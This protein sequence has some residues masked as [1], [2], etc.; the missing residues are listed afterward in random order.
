MRRTIAGALR[1]A[2]VGGLTL[3]GACAPLPFPEPHAVP[4]ASIRGPV[5]TF[6]VPTDAAPS[7]VVEL[8]LRGEE[9]P[10]NG[11]G[12]VSVSSVPVCEAA[13]LVVATAL[14]GSVACTVPP[15]SRV[16]VHVSE[17]DP[18][19]VLAAFI[20]AV[21]RL[22]VETVVRGGTLVLSGG[23]P[24][25]AEGYG[26]PPPAGLPGTDPAGA[27]TFTLETDPGSDVTLAAVLGQLANP[28][29]APL[30]ADLRAEDVR[31]ILA[32]VGVAGDVIEV[33]GRSFLVSDAPSSEALLPLLSGLDHAAVPV[34]S[35]GIS[36][37][38]LEVMRD[39]YPGVGFRPDPGS[40]VVWLTG[41]SDAVAR[42]ASEFS[43]F[44]LPVGDMRV[45]AAFLS[46]AS[47]FSEG[48]GIEAAASVDLGQHVT[49]RAG[50]STPSR[51]VELAVERF[52]SI[53]GARVVSR[54][55][56][57]VRP[58]EPARFV[59]GQSVPIL[60]GVPAGGDAGSEGLEVAYRDVGV[61][62][63]AVPT[64]LPNGQVRI[65]I[66]LEVSTISGTGVA[67]N[68]VFETQSVTT[69]VDVSSGDLVVLS[70]LKELVVQGS[71]TKR[72][73]IFNVE[74]VDNSERDLVFLLTVRKDGENAALHLRK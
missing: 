59:S 21:R 61:V 10:L 45:D 71:K 52:V 68:P 43:D 63:E 27:Q 4:A 33:R 6:G 58:G 8:F 9:L 38:A 37:V 67:E 72:L 54:P 55:S 12:P 29:V 73:G 15:S 22:E 26:Y 57:T 40:A 44:F 66:T 20:A 48:F 60:A 28:S 19:L 62:I 2:S 17:R 23:T 69:S 50:S 42:A 11:S 56:V 64:P 3:V 16:S 49:V 34:S 24:G 47:S 25:D 74:G 1:A 46:V 36:P 30:P 31:S 65:D 41:S 14:G 35:S 13:E 39:T 32:G 51:T 70:G 53:F 5:E 18:Q 7:E